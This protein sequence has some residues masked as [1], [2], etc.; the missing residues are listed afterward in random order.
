MNTETI[1]VQAENLSKS[2]GSFKAVDDVSLIVK[3]G[4][5]LGFLGPNG[6][7]KTTTMK[8]L[9]GFLRMDVGRV[10]ICGED[11]STGGA[12]LRRKIGYLPE[13]APLYPDMTV[14]EYLS[15]IAECHGITGDVAADVIASASHAVNIDEVLDR[16]LDTLSKGF[17]RRVGF[18]GAILHA[19]DVL[20]LDEPTDGLDPN[21]K[22]EIRSLIETMAVDRAIIIS[23]HILE[24]VASLCTRTVVMSSGKLVADATPT[25]LMA[26]SS[27]NGAVTMLVDHIAAEKIA[28]RLSQMRVISKVD[29]IREGTQ[30]RLTVFPEAGEE[31]ASRISDMASISG[32]PISA[33][34]VENGRLDDV[35]RMLT[36]RDPDVVRHAVA[37]FQKNYQQE[38]PYAY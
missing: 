8:C 32:W 30:M 18:A 34:T 12:D 10:L 2:F 24:E 1:L 11:I 35:F 9:T 37:E 28:A 17:R 27:Y 33:L 22:H 16:T 6:A 19:P 26:M 3:K 36:T 31:I 13:G 5:I 14:R 21:Q 15:F 23:T 20:I 38:R 29:A 7:G 25:E 4:E